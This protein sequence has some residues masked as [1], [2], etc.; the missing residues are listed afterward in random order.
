MY[1]YTIYILVYHILQ[2]TLFHSYNFINFKKNSKIIKY[3]ITSIIF[4]Y[5]TINYYKLN[6][7]FS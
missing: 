6:F 1:I 2:Y 4:L 3:S 7:L 5:Y